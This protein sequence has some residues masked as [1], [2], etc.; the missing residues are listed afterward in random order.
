M[1]TS[2]NIRHAC[3]LVAALCLIGTNGQAQSTRDIT[4]LTVQAC[5]AET[6]TLKAMTD[7]LAHIGWTRV[8]QADMSDEQLYHWAS[9]HLIDQMTFA[10]QGADFWKFKW[11]RTQT[12]ARGLRRKVEEV[13]LDVSTIY[14]GHENDSHVLQLVLQNTDSFDYAVCSFVA[15][16]DFAASL[17]PIVNTELNDSMP[18]IV[19]LRPQEF[20]G[21]GVTRTLRI[22]LLR[23]EAISGLLEEDFPFIAQISST[24]RIPR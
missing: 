2:S 20:G 17:A 8:K 6:P 24:Q 14:F 7:A 23:N 11:D 1:G 13:G 16:A 21:G 22:R 9:Q 15:K 18:A 10:S 3:A 4:E 12:N 5:I 19:V